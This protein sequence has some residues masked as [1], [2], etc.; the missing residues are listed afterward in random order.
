MAS[1]ANNVACVWIAHLH[2]HLDEDAKKAQLWSWLSAKCVSWWPLGSSGVGTTICPLGSSF[3][4]DLFDLLLLFTK[5]RLARDG[6]PRMSKVIYSAKSR[7]EALHIDLSFA[8]PNVWI[9][10]AENYQRHNLHL[11]VDG[12]SQW[13]S[14]IPA[15]QPCDNCLR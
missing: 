13:C 8:E 4:V 7:A 1:I 10:D 3:I 11:V 2:A 9:T 5:S 15:A 12:Q 14:L 6:Q